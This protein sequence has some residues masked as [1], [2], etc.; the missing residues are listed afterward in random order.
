MTA[1]SVLLVGAACWA[2]VVA[3][4]PDLGV[5]GAAYPDLVVAGVACPGLVGVAEA[6]VA[7]AG[8][9]GVAFQDQGAAYLME[10]TTTDNK[11]KQ[12]ELLI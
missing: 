3:A 10:T 9:A 1:R 12:N 11:R 5:V 6:G 2:G 7:E 4:Y 8:P